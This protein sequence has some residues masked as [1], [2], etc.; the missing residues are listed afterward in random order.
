MYDTE[1]LVQRQAKA[2]DDG[3]RWYLVRTKPKQE[4]RAERNL[5]AWGIETMAPTI[6]EWRE[7][8]P[9]TMTKETKALFPG[10]LFA[11]FNLAAQLVRVRLTR[12]V[13]NVVGFGE[14]AT[15]PCSR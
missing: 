6:R 13:N 11:R 5:C 12:G 2:I 15:E 10:Y 1:T 8:Q 9:P 7:S 14:C 3:M 4:L